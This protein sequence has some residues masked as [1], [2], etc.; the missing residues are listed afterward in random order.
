MRIKG[1]LLFS[2]IAISSV[3]SS[4][5]SFCLKDTVYRDYYGNII[6]MPMDLSVLWSNVN[7]SSL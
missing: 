7:K 5:T 3:G 1:F 4:A 6:K 2:L